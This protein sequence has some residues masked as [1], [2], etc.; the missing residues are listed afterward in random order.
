M[1]NQACHG[2]HFA[3]KT[4]IELLCYTPGVNLM[5]YVNYIKFIPI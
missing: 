3:V 4:N 1:D 2:D 5:F